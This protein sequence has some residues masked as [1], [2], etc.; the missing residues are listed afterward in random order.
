MNS[1]TIP[2]FIWDNLIMILLILRYLN[3]QILSQKSVG[4]ILPDIAGKC[5]EILGC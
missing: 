5:V 4:V 2:I 3:V 1:L